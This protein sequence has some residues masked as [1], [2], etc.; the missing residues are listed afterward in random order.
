MIESKPQFL[1]GVYPFIGSGYEKVAPLS[2]KLV[3]VVPADKRAQLIYLR[4]GNSS[5]DLLY[6]VLM[7]DGVPMRYFPVAAKGTAHVSLA[8]VEDLEPG[9]R[10]EVFYGA[11][12]A[13]HGSLVIDI[14]LL[15][16]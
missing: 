1:Q 10:L 6:L 15:E 16:I 14:G 8:V 2:E 4:L 9:T 13:A 3:Y 5:A 12:M 11:Q 7:R